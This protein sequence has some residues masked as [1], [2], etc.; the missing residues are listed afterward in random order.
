MRWQDTIKL[1]TVTYEKD[2]IG[3]Q[4]ETPTDRL[5]RANPWVV[6]YQERSEAGSDTGKGRL[7]YEVQT[8]VYRD[9]RLAEVGGRKYTVDADKRGFRTVLTLEEVPGYGG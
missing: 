2:G 3:Q 7:R 9:E 1:I 5:I 4:V 6:S 8:Q